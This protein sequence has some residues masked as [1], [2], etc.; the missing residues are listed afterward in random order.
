[1]IV[2]TSDSESPNVTCPANRVKETDVGRAFATLTLPPAMSVSD[3]VGIASVS[4]E[5]S[6]S[7]YVPNDNITLI[8]SQ[9]PHT[10]RYLAHDAA[11]NT[12]GCSVI[13]TVVGEYF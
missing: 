11:G 8:F 10:L 2:S 13:M 4:V 12:D 6:G 5:F 1:M 9:S 7:V 3:N